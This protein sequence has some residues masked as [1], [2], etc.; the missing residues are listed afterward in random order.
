V[1]YTKEICVHEIAHKYDDEHKISS[2]Q[3]YRDFI[4]T[5]RAILYLCPECRDQ[6]SD[7][8]VFFPG[9][10]SESLIEGDITAIDFW[11]GGWGGYDEMYAEMAEYYYGNDFPYG[12]EDFYDLEYISN[13]L[14][15]LGY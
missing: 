8:I 11:T 6:Y 4:A 14:K 2:S 10:G 15:M 7:I 9:I 3:K 12:A 1:C 5:Y 13:E